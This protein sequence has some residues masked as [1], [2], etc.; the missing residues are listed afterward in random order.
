MAG[1]QLFVIVFHGGFKM[2]KFKVSRACL[3]DSRACFG[4][5]RVPR[6]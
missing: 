2:S 4:D 1:K 3:E 6:G 5:N